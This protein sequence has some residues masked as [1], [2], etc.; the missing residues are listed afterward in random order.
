MNTNRQWLLSK[1]PF[2]EVGVDNFGNHS[3]TFKQYDTYD[4]YKKVSK[5]GSKGATPKFSFGHDHRHI[6]LG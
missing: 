4:L 3:P 5:Y 2:G 6:D 1:R